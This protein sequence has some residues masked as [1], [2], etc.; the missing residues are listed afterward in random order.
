MTPRLEK[1]FSRKGSVLVM[2]ALAAVFLVSMTALVTDVGHVYYNQ[3]RLQTAV[4]AGWKAGFDKLMQKK[5]AS[6]ELDPKDYNEIR[7][8][9]KEVMKANGYTDDELSGVTINFGLTNQIEIISSQPVGLF[10]A[11]VM[12]FNSVDVAASRA[13]HAEDLNTTV[14]PLAI[15]HGVVKDLS[16]STYS[17]DFFDPNG[18]F[19]TDTEYIIKLGSGGGNTSLPPNDP[20]YKA[21]LVPMDNGSQSSDGYLRAYGAAFWC[22]K[23]DEADPGFVPVQW[24]LGYRGGSFMLPYEKDVM[25]IL[26]DYNV[27]YTV[28]TGS[29]NVQAIYDQV[30][31]N[32]LELYNRPRI[33]VYSSQ[34]GDDPVEVVLKAGK[35][36][37]GTYSLPPSVDKNGWDR[38]SAYSTKNSTHVW[39][40][41]IL[42]GDLDKYHW[43]HLHHEDFT[44]FNGGCS[45][46]FY[47]CKD[48]YDKGW[49]G[50][51][52]SSSKR[53][54]CKEKMCSYCRGK[55]NYST[56][57][58]SNYY[59]TSGV[60]VTNCQNTRR[61]CA[62]KA[63]YQGKLWRDDSSVYICNKGDT[64][65]PQC[66]QYNDL[67]AIAQ[68]R[69]YTSDANSEPKPHYA[70]YSDGSYPL[71]D[72]YPGWF[73]KATDVQKMKWDLVAAIKEHVNQGGFLFAQCFAPETFDIS[74]WQSAIYMGIK[75]ENAYSNCVA[76]ENF[77]YKIFPRKEGR[78]W[79][80][81]INSRE[82]SGKFDLLLPLDPRCQNHGTGYCCDT[83]QGHTASFL[84]GKLKSTTEILGNQSGTG[85]SWVKYIK[86][87]VGDGDFTFLGGH[88]HNNT[89]TRRLV[90]NNILLGSLVE[91]EVTGGGGT[92][93]DSVV[94]KTKS[95]YGPIDPD[96][97]V[98]GG[99][100]DYRDRFKFGFTSPLQLSDRIIPE[101]G[102]MVGP[103]DQAVDFKV[104]GDDTYPPSRKVII[105]ITDVAPEVPTN[106]KKNED[107]TT[108]YDLQGTDHP[109]GI[110][111]PALYGFG[112]S[113]RIIGFAE[114]EILDP[115]EYTRDGVNVQSGDQGDL[116]TYQAGQVRGKFIR[117]I[118][119]PGEM[120]V[121]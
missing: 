30:N 16:K 46:W 119:K 92:P 76:F 34:E 65:Y 35:I 94:G 23:I 32:I 27:N 99:A 54:A 69:S 26:N 11:R 110:Y 104:N 51:T 57:K 40:N 41:E 89:Y 88:Y 48:F 112:A 80:S 113:V 97:T 13:N 59:P 15:P 115:S 8:H 31:P 71:P 53:K 19:A 22:L 111:D 58:W 60:N 37:Y 39:D 66:W 91:K 4:N 47:D 98:G 20:E 109:K 83:G 28:I 52:S 62:E 114:F 84:K 107:A 67:K 78:A 72:N 105:P 75:P 38:K 3:A 5:N 82:G 45:Y 63:S 7:N 74:L 77:N 118:V 116:G 86:G 121:N 85:G 64:S 44:G 18:G 106:N 79:Y 21:I 93:V 117:Y 73:D 120:P 101:S 14:I 95:N 12:D 49:L 24:L 10:F 56:G 108:I 81:T 2:T 55:F 102:N 42:A 96:N 6:P 61:R 33:A 70:V 29:E 25:G 50:S 103:T 17:C 100:N 87:K 90:L 36:P 43:L 68:N 1:F 9:V